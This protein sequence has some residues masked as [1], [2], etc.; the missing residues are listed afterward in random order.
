MTKI[1]TF[2]LLYTLGLLVTAG[3]KEKK[4]STIE[5]LWVLMV[6]GLV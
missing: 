5:K 4:I 6:V 1:V 3:K 2:V